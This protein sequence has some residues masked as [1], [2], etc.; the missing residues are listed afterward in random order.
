MKDNKKY[1]DGSLSE[2]EPHRLTGS[3]IIWNDQGVE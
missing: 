2:N 1:I 3:G